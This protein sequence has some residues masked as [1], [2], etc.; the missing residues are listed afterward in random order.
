MVDVYGRCLLKTGKT[1]T[2]I[3]VV[4]GQVYHMNKYQVYDIETAPANILV[5]LL[6]RTNQFLFQN[7]GQKLDR[8]VDQIKSDPWTDTESRV[9]CRWKQPASYSLTS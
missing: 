9:S 2:Q 3:F 8:F 5:V 4:F 1:R 6:I 7:F